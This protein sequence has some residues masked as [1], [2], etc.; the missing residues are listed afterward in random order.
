MKRVWIIIAM[1]VFMA[2]NSSKPVAKTVQKTKKMLPCEEN[3]DPS[4]ISALG[5]GESHDQFIAEKVAMNEGRK[6]LTSDI[7]D[8]MQKQL[9]SYIS[10]NN[11]SNFISAKLRQ[12]AEAV[13]QVSLSKLNEN[14]SIDSTLTDGTHRVYKNLSVKKA[15]VKKELLDEVSLDAFLMNNIDT[16]TLSSQLNL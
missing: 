16:L 8:Q 3:K 13:S 7:N 9:N 5:I 10:K 15:D 11:L 14:C 12:S 2:C 6:Q 4:S 1:A